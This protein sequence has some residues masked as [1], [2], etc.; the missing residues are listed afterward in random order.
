VRTACGKAAVQLIGAN[1][2]PLVGPTEYRYSCYYA[3]DFR[4]RGRKPKSHNGGQV[5]EINR[6]QLSSL[7]PVSPQAIVENNTYLGETERVLARNGHQTSA[8]HRHAERPATDDR[9]SGA[10]AQHCA[11]TGP[12]MRHR[13]ST[14]A[15]PQQTNHA[16]QDLN[17][18]SE[19]ILD[20]QIPPPR[21]GR[22]SFSTAQLT[23][24]PG[25][26]LQAGP[27]PQAQPS[28]FRPYPCLE[29]IRPLLDDLICP[30]DAC[31]LLRFYFAR[32]G[33]SLFRSASP[34]VLTHVLRKKSLL[35]PTKPRE[36]TPALLTTMLWVSAQTA[37]IPLLLLPGERSRVCEALRKLSTSLVH[38][39]DHDHWQRSPG[40]QSN[41]PTCV[42]RHADTEGKEA[43]FYST[44]STS[45]A[46]RI[47]ASNLQS[48]N[49]QIRPCRS[50]TTFSHSY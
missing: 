24:N 39:R 1:H 18:P 16:E 13:T 37:D 17:H 36:T 25:V 9:F 32:P 43:V 50:S 21:D 14:F 40:E 23:N 19:L 35:H 30:E 10:S 48:N 38:D 12:S 26:E 44:V 31:E 46:R 7:V 11:S 22:E 27:P 4:R 41:M 34:Y 42:P 3:R 2:H 8:L 49:K 28:A 20:S 29:P 5:S 33:S 47:L 45:T 15:F 6:A